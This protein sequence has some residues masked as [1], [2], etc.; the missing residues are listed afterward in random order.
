MLN[1]KCYQGMP[2][3]DLIL[4][5]IL[6]GFVLYGF[7]FGLIHTLGGL[8]GVVVASIFATRLYEPLG[9]WALLIF[10]GP[11]NIIRVI[12]FIIVFFLIT[13]LVG[14]V[15]YIAERIFKFISI[16]PFLKSINRLL[17]AILGFAEGV[18]LVGGIL[19]VMAITPLPRL[20]QALQYSNVARYLVNTYRVMTPLLPREL[21]EFDPSDYFRI[22]N[23]REVLPVP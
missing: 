3:V 22:P 4:L 10:G 23:P 2:T 16:V 19:F 12:I 7:W 8:V 6:F 9:E 13:R 15:F 17:G 20:E 18:F 14:F 1:V 5:I 11:S 21:R